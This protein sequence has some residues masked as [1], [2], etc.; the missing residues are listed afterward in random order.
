MH[1]ATRAAVWRRAGAHCEYCRLHQDDDPF[2]TFHVEHIIAR[3]T[4]GSAGHRC[5]AAPSAR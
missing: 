4:A 2:A 5:T 3:Q 1:S